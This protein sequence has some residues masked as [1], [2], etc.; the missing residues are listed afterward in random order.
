MKFS[1]KTF[2]LLGIVQCVILT[3]VLILFLRYQ[4]SLESKDPASTTESDFK[5]AP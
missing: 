1:A 2:V 5:A 4:Q 3:L